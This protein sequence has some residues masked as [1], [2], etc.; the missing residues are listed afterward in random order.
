M[1]F[2]EFPN[3]VYD[4]RYGKTTKT[5]IVKDITR[6]VRFRKE[7][8]SNITLYDEYD[9]ID[10]ETPEII[11]EKIYG[12]PEYHWIIML[13]NERFDYLSD[14]P[15]EEY[16][17]VKHIESTYGENA[18]DVRYYEDA[19]GFVVNSDVPGAIA[20]TNAEYERILNE[21][22]RRINIVSPQI[23]NAVIKNFE[24]II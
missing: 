10:G 11:A 1:Y 14:F 13:C 3:F 16:S 2:N 21:K 24:D 8:L 12:N 22:K 20:I 6:N 18:N 7:V 15:L 9:I 23:I 19:R 17:L 5:S 4:F